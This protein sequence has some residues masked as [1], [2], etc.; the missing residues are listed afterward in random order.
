MTVKAMTALDY[1]FSKQ[2]GHLLRKALQRNQMIYAKLCVDPDMTSVQFAVLYV[3]ADKAPCSMAVIGRTAAMD[4]ATTRGVI[5]RLEKRKLISLSPDPE[6]K[7]KV[8]VQLLPAGAELVRKMLPQS[9]KV[10]ELTMGSLNPA[11]RVALIYLL[12]KIATP[13]DD[14]SLEG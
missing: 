10:G 2:V 7:R 14:E 1:D 6:D 11:E 8:L 13:S 12:E 9:K 4:A 5:E 3:L